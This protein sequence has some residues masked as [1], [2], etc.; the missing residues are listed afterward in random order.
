V[1][2]PQDWGRER[3]LGK[4]KTKQNPVKMS[5][6]EDYRNIFFDMISSEIELISSWGQ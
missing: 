1:E 4:N 2:F 6:K 3:Q 5:K